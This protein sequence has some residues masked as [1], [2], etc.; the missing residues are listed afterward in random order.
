MTGK[1]HHIAADASPPPPS[2]LY[3]HAVQADGWLHV[4]GQ[5]PTD[6][7]APAVPLRSGIEAQSEMCF[8]NIHRILRHAGY[9]LADAVFVRI[10]LSEF[11]R[12][13]AAFNSVY[14][15][16]FPQDRPLP[17]RTTVGVAALGRRA[18]VEIDL[19]CFNASLR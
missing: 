14:V 8:E 19:I 11:E 3:S 16:H 15:R 17:S 13:F 18:L 4:T 6:P 1:I 7:D 12:D 9:A 10:Y 5:L 2:S